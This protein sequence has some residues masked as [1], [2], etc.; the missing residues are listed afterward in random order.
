MNRHWK[1][2]NY[3]HITGVLCQTRKGRITRKCGIN[4]KVLR[5]RSLCSNTSSSLLRSI[6]SLKAKLS[7]PLKLF[8]WRFFVGK[9]TIMLRQTLSQ[10]L[11]LGELSILLEFWHKS[12]GF[13]VISRSMLSYLGSLCGT[14]N[15]PWKG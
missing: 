10:Q 13:K 3:R 2:A 12:V 6:A 7:T 4:G 9:L 14:G 8:Q 15:T 1:H 11:R 5:F